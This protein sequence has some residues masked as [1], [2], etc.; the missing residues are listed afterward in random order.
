MNQKC[1]KTAFLSFMK[2][3]RAN[4]R[5]WGNMLP[6]SIRTI[7]HHGAPSTGSIIVHSRSL[8]IIQPSFYLPINGGGENKLQQRKS[9]LHRQTLENCYQNK[10]TSCTSKTEELVIESAWDDKSISQ[11]SRKKLTA[12]KADAPEYFPCNVGRLNTL[13]LHRRRGGLNVLRRWWRG[14][15]RLT[16]AGAASERASVGSWERETFASSE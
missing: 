15:S 1:S 2:K 5:F 16:N 9:E 6:C 7:S 13:E 11:E 10:F 14:N 4:K 12:L 8:A 3:Q